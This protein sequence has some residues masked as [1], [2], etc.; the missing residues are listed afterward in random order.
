MKK[1]GPVL[2]VGTLFISFVISMKQQMRDTCTN[3]FRQALRRDVGLVLLLFPEVKQQY[4]PAGGRFGRDDAALIA[5]YRDNAVLCPS[6]MMARL[7]SQVQV[8]TYVYGWGP[9]G[10]R[11]IAWI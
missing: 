11:L 4:F 10:S 3:R 2:H 6:V 9:K 7:A 8:D 1:V 5:S